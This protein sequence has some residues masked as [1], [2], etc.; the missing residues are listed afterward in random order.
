VYVLK[1]IVVIKG[2]IK[3]LYLF[4]KFLAFFDAYQLTLTPF[5]TMNLQ[6]IL[7]YSNICRLGKST[8]RPIQVKKRSS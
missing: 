3:N 8:D 2:F 6:V 5:R 7:N 4:F 1:Q